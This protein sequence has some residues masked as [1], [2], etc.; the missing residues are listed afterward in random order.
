[1][2]LAALM[3][4][5]PARQAK[6]T[7]V[8]KGTA[9]PGGDARTLPLAFGEGGTP[10]TS[11]QTAP[12]LASNEAHRA[13]HDSAAQTPASVGSEI[14]NEHVLSFFN[15]A[16]KQAFIRLAREQGAQILG[17]MSLGNSVRIRVGSEAQYRHLLESGPT[18][19]RVAPNQSVRLPPSPS[20][21]PRTSDGRYV[22]FGDHMLD[23]LGVKGDH[24]AWGK[25]VTVALLDTA[26]ARHASIPESQIRRVNPFG[27]E[28]GDDATSHGTAVASLIIG[29]GNG[30]VGLAPSAKLLS[31]P[32]VGAEG[33]GDAFTL[34]QGIMEAVTLGADII[35][36]SLGGAGE[37]FIL[38]EAI[39]HARANGVVVVAAVGNEGV[40]GIAYPAREDDVIAVGAVDAAYR[41]LYFSNTGPELDIAAPG[42]AINAAGPEDGTVAFSGTSAATPITSAA[43]AAVMS[44]TAGMTADQAI[45]LIID[46]GDDYGAPGEDAAYGQGILNMGRIMQRNQPGIYDVTAGGPYILIPDDS[47]DALMIE[48]YA[49]NRGTEPIEEMTLNV[50]I[51]GVP[52]VLHFQNIAVGQTVSERVTVPPEIIPADGH[53]TATHAAVITGHRD[54]NPRDNG[55]RSVFFLAPESEK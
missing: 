5:S 18:P 23:W 6:T 35:N 42:L 39:A 28:D 33:G 29:N 40:D 2:L 17:E 53:V 8:R 7:G 12:T 45:Q 26:V 54:A 55:Q 11:G 16:D 41:H 48:F 32:V 21:P 4:W 47:S 44:A 34:A 43:V 49:Q 31:I 27:I 13:G 20:S 1:M 52:S 14:P 19:T 22:A 37:S 51:E 46:Y 9:L 15:Q 10:K 30:I 25:G 24:Q 38:A 36:L 3:F 50:T